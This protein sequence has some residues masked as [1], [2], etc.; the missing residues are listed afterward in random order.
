MELC[1]VLAVHVFLVR[2]LWR[3]GVLF[4]HRPVLGRWNMV[5]LRGV[6]A[7]ASVVG[8]QAGSSQ[9]VVDAGNLMRP[10]WHV[11]EAYCHAELHFWLGTLDACEVRSTPCCMHAR[12]AEPA[13]SEDC[14]APHRLSVNLLIAAARTAL[15]CRR[16]LFEIE[17]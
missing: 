6:L 4:H 3:C 5:E 11:V 14:A 9:P 13:G 10:L 15:Q 1:G 12:R 16:E 2:G 7:A 17:N 8:L